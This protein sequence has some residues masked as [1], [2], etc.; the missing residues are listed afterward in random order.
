MNIAVL[1]KVV[2]NFGD[3]GVVWRLCCQLSNQI[4]KENFT[5]KINLIVD[6]LASFNKICNSV[7][8][9]KSFQI[10]DNI[11]IFNWNDEKLCYDEFSKN[12][13]ENLSVILEV[14]QCGRPSWMEK[15]LFGDK[16]NRT[17][18][19]IM[20]DYLTA[21][22]YAED[23]HCLQ[24]LTRS[25]KVQKVN[26][27]PGFTNKTGG[28]IIDS[29]W[30]HFCDYKN[31][32]TLLCFTYDRNWDALAN[33]CKKSN[34]IEKVL[35]APGKGFDSLKKSFSC[36]FVKDSNL[37]IEE[38]SFM[39]QNEWDK[40]LKN[41]GVL[42]I[43]G[44]ESMSR[45]CLSGIP[46]VWHAYP[47]SDEYQLIK[48]RALLERMSVHFKCEDFKIIEK[49]WI[50]INSAESE[51]EQEEFE[52]AILDFFDNAEKLVY[53]FREFALD[54]RKN[55]DLCSNLMT[56]IKNKCIM[57]GNNRNLF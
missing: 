15:I 48:V 17:V 8:A 41:C 2:D 1:C 24:S 12:D 45:A 50:L 23:F 49:V 7:D 52:K 42:F 39:N 46:F 44:E 55:G 13:G 37:K 57:L 27:M 3:I 5:S 33:A 51:V 14:F 21:E 56:F 11:N 22:K 9:N 20:I 35:I 26:F 43:R 30:K 10:V 29:E 47:Q 16:L 54:L 53:G 4:K 6:D 34:Y 31:N 32:K 36:N 38:L 40:M 19:I 25:S 18:Q 28:L